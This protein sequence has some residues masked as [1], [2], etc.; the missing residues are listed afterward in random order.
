MN[1]LLQQHSNRLSG[2]KRDGFTVI[3][4]VVVIAVIVLLSAIVA[5]LAITVIR[6]ARIAKTQGDVSSIAK[7]IQRYRIDTGA[8]PFKNS[9]S[10]PL[11]P[12]FATLSTANGTNPTVQASVTTWSAPVDAYDGT[13]CGT[14]G[15][16]GTDT[17]SDTL[18]LN[19]HLLSNGP[20]WAE[21][22]KPRKKQWKGTYV[23]ELD[24][25]AW[26]NKILVNILNGFRDCKK[27]LYVLSAGPDGEVDTEFDLALTGTSADDDIIARIR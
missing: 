19:E 23:S 27:A 20:S 15:N 4:M 2:G 8:Y 21:D 13:A 9:S 25:D 14:S 18:R 6:D 17:G 16:P 24:E 11:S 7:A 12:D 10:S 5:P 3:E 1:T 22:Q 26:G